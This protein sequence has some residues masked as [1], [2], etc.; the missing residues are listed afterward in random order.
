MDDAPAPISI[1]ESFLGLGPVL[2]DGGIRRGSD[3][4][5][6][7]ASGAHGVLVGRSILYGLAARG[8][9]GAS[10][11]LSIL[12]EELDRALALVGCSDVSRLSNAFIDPR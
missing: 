3:V 11:A 5:K 12:I 7:L 1:L 6:S 10:E 2:I 4:L 8:E 9:T